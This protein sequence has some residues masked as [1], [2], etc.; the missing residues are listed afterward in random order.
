VTNKFPDFASA[1]LLPKLPIGGFL[2]PSKARA[3]TV[4]SVNKDIAAS[5]FF[6]VMG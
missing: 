1:G 5:N 4:K 2:I 3:L 6:I